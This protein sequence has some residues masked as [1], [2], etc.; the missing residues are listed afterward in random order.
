MGSQGHVAPGSACAGQYPALPAPAARGIYGSCGEQRCAPSVALFCVSPCS[1]ACIGCKCLTSLY[2][3][4]LNWCRNR[5][6]SPSWGCEGTSGCTSWLG[7]SRAQ[8][9]MLCVPRLARVD[10]RSAG[11]PACTAGDLCTAQGK[12]P[13]IV[14]RQ[15]V[16]LLPATGASPRCN[17]VSFSQGALSSYLAGEASVW[18][19]ASLPTAVSP[20]TVVVRCAQPHGPLMIQCDACEGP[21]GQGAPCAGGDGRVPIAAGHSDP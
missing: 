14:V 18:Q 8:T 2:T 11:V 9:S 19:G 12:I 10:S 5:L 3:A 15:G 21:G 13:G 4:F 20:L 6:L 7:C 17:L 1:M 16:H